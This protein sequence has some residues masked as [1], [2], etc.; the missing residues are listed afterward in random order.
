MVKKPVEGQID[1]KR[2]MGAYII[3]HKWV[4]S[5]CEDP[6]HLMLFKFAENS[7]GHYIGTTK[8]AHRLVHRYGI[9]TF[10]LRTATSK[11]C[12]IGFNPDTRTWYGWSHRAIKGFTGSHAKQKAKR[13][14]ES[15][16]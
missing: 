11:T 9:R 6:V 15:V 10:E 4:D 12:S 7:D 2:D 1:F 14:A 5:H 3:V 16:S 13:F 8:F